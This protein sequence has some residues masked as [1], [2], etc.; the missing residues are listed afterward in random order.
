[1]EELDKQNKIQ[2]NNQQTANIDLSETD[3]DKPNRYA[4]PAAIVIAGLL[5]SGA[6]L[7]NNR[8]KKAEKT[9]IYQK[10]NQAGNS[11]V[12]NVSP[13]DDPFLGLENAPVTLIYFSDYQCPFCRKF[14]KENLPKIKENYID[15]GK[16]KFV[17][18]DFPLD[19]LHPGARPAA[20]AAECADDQNKFWQMHDKIFEEQDKLGQGTQEFD[21]ADIKKWAEKINLDMN[22][23]N[24]CLDAN[25]YKDEVEKDYQDGLAA[26]VSGTPTSFINGKKV[27]GAVP[28]NT[29]ELIIKDALEKVEK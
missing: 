20:Q 15:T 21:I 4:I 23:F 17:Y 7:Y 5:I 28:Y 24:Q 19:N 25:K 14:W 9:A 10:E 12:V 26:D 29:I 18:R 11:E 3:E 8:E 2:E 16:L 1:M 6:V 22:Q 13:D 27:V